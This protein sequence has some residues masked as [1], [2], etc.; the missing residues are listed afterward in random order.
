MT[1]SFRLSIYLDFT[2]FIDLY[3]GRYICSSVH[4][5]MKTDF[6]QTVNLLTIELQLRVELRINQFI[7]IFFFFGFPLEPGL[8]SSL[9]ADIGQAP[10]VQTLNST[11][12]RI[13]HYPADKY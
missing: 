13:N 9:M 12:H 5:K 4:P 7:I 8:K 1:H 6:I 2:D 3:I 10:V 11:I